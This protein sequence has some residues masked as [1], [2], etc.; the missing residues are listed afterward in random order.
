MVFKT[1]LSW[2]Q[3]YG[4]TTSRK[5]AKFSEAGR[6]LSLTVAI[7]RLNEELSRLGVRDA[8]HDVVIYTNLSV[9]LSGF[10]RAYS[11][12]PSD[13]GV[14]VNWEVNG[15]PRNMPIDIYKRV[16]DNIAAIAAT[17]K[18]MRDIERHGGKVIQDK[19]MEAF[20]ALPAPDSCWQ[21]LN[22]HL[23]PKHQV[24]KEVVVNHFKEAATKLVDHRGMPVDMN[25]LVQA[26][27]EALASIRGE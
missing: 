16:A 17:L 8:E 19:A 10:P 13:P 25:V 23:L 22:L 24:T 2:P 11:S 12:E 21:I 5:D 3:G 1:P 6:S 27:D 15:K 7:K 9:S 4:R 14:V 20:D 18:A 26:R